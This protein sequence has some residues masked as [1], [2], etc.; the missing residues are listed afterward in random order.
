MSEKDAAGFDIPVAMVLAAGF[1]KRLEPLTRMVPKPLLPVCNRPV[2]EHTLRLLHELGVREVVMNLHH[3]GQALMERLGDGGR[4]GVSIIY[5]QEEELLG[6]AGGIKAAEGYLRGGPFLVINSD[7]LIELDLRDAWNFHKEKNALAT[8]ILREEEARKYGVISIDDE[9]RVVRFLDTSSREGGPVAVETMF[10]GVQI[11]EP[12]VLDRIPPHIPWGSAEELYP[13]LMREGAALHGYLMKGAWVDMGTPERYLEANFMALERSFYTIF[14]E[15]EGS[16]EGMNPAASPAE[17]AR[18]EWRP[19]VLRG[20]GCRLEEGCV[21]G[22]RLI[23][24]DDCRVG[25]D[26]RLSNCVIWEGVTI[27]RGSFLTDCIVADGVTIPPGSVIRWSMVVR[28]QSGAHSIHP[29]MD[30]R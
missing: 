23:M 26:T 18:V 5:S 27:G 3:L 21:L 4:M 13:S 17:D 6:T 19:P 10:T 15:N 30:W 14:G 16:G 9:G 1:G 8:L 25:R 11:L 22:P 20:E 2:V 29:I 28:G 7:I 12:P 24:G